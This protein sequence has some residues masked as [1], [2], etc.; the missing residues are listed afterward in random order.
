MLIDDFLPKGRMKKSKILTRD[1][2]APSKRINMNALGSLC[3][4]MNQKIQPTWGYS[5]CFLVTTLFHLGET[6]CIYLS[7]DIKYPILNNNPQDLFHFY[8]YFNDD[9]HSTRTGYVLNLSALGWSHTLFL[10]VI[11]L[12]ETS[13]CWMDVCCL[14]CDVL[15]GFGHRVR[16]VIIHSAF[17][18]YVNNLHQRFSS[19][20]YRIQYVVNYCLCVCFNRF[21]CK[22]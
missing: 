15:G 8:R 11:W 17:F 7:F 2:N 3:I 12:V 21:L 1:R 18:K 13:S 20:T 19:C 22:S 6:Q 5:G 14:S 16:F 9:R 4:L 10:P